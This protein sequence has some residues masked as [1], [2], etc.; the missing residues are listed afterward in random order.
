MLDNFEE[1]YFKFYKLMYVRKNYTPSKCEDKIVKLLQI[2][3]RSS[4]PEPF[5]RV[6]NSENILVKPSFLLYLIQS[7]AFLGPLDSFS[8]IL[9]K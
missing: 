8:F 6:K 9:E 5:L 2:G 3:E 4:I 1:I 7:E